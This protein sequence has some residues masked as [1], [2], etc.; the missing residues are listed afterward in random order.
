MG[1]KKYMTEEEREEAR[2]LQNKLAQR[3]YR[4]RKKCQGNTTPSIG[5]DKRRAKKRTNRRILKQASKDVGRP[6]SESRLPERPSA[7]PMLEKG[8]VES[9][10]RISQNTIDPSVR[11]NSGMVEQASIDVGCLES[12]WNVPGDPSARLMLE[13]QLTRTMEDLENVA[14]TLQST[15]DSLARECMREQRPCI[16]RMI[17]KL[18]ALQED[19]SESAEASFKGETT[20]SATDSTHH[21]PVQLNAVPDYQP[22]SESPL[23]VSKPSSGDMIRSLRARVRQ[24]KLLGSIGWGYTVENRT[25][26][27]S[28]IT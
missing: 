23:K 5:T 14:R 17:D 28:R 22:C 27:M 8:N 7:R 6:E 4:E 25:V 15:T 12:E 3:A 18:Q 26:P 9:I 2:R 24:L 11:T 1:R 19:R 13:M 10:A 20:S 16:Q 21:L